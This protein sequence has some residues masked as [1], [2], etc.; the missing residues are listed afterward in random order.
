M[1]R[2]HI[3]ILLVVVLVIAGWFLRPSVPPVR[4]QAYVF[5]RKAA[6]WNRLATVR[7][8]V[9][10]LR[11]GQRV[12][13]IESKPWAGGEYKRVL[14]ADGS[15]G[16]MDSR[17]LI[18]AEIWQRARSNLEKS[19]SMAQ[20]AR[21]KTKV[22]TNL[23]VEP[24]RAAARSFQLS[25]AV[26]VEILARAVVERPK[27]E[28]ATAKKLEE[29]T[30]EQTASP[31]RED[32]LLVSTHD[33]DAGDLA[34]WVLGRF[35]EPNLPSPLRDYAAGIRFVAWFELNRVPA[36]STELS[37]EAK[38]MTG[39]PPKQP[40]MMLQYLA[41]GVTG[42]EGQPCDFTLL[43]FYTWNS[44]RRR[45][46]TAYIESNFCAH[47]PI[48]VTSIPPGANLEKSEASFSFSAAGKSGDETREYR[49]KQNVVRRLRARK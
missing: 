34:G 42:G 38:S 14:V 26:P 37:S 29:Q 8:P 10:S 18:P 35:I 16:W 7:E 5:E 45:Y 27:E 3:V 30:G 40:P 2:N 31:R 4:E 9:A 13:I 43:R 21:G 28:S 1:R 44:T 46:E 20:Q 49:M 32:W 23:R 12:D 22:P 19:R 6:I 24:G 17:Q 41:A 39:E 33:E 15:S 25:G 47:F 11:Y 36:S 48:R